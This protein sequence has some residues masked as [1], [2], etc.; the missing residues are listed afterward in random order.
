[1]HFPEDDFL[2]QLTSVELGIRH[3]PD[4]P[5]GGGELKGRTPATIMTPQT[6]EMSNGPSAPAQLASLP[7]GPVGWV[8]HRELFKLFDQPFDQNARFGIAQTARQDFV[9]KDVA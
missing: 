8:R 2:H 1:M 3:R 4:K 5:R 6:N 9:V 7:I